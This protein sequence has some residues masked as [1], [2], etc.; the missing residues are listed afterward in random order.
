LN[1]TGVGVT[2]PPPL[3]PPVA[4]PQPTTAAPASG[5]RSGNG[6]SGQQPERQQEQRAHASAAQDAPPLR[7]L[8]VTE[9]RVMLGQLPAS[10]AFK[11]EQQHADPSAAA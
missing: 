4:P 2:P 9:M 1:V 5:G 3:L 7:V 11:L 6:T 10:A 8:T